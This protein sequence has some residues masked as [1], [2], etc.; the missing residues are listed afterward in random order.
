M[1]TREDVVEVVRQDLNDEDQDWPEA[2]WSFTR[3]DVGSYLFTLGAVH[4]AERLDMYNREGD[5]SLD[6][7]IA[8]TNVPLHVV[9]CDMCYKIVYIVQPDDSLVAYSEASR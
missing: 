6:D 9:P 2:E 7:V 4:W 5:Y 3:Q 1:I 8:L